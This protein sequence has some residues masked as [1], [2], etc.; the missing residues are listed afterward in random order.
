MIMLEKFIDAVNESHIN[1][2]SIIITKNNHTERHFFTETEEDAF[3]SVRSISKTVSCLGAFVAVEK[4]VYDLETNILQFFDRDKIT[5]ENNI[6]FL[7]KMK[8]KH[9]MNLTIGREKDL[10]FSKDIKE[11]IKEYPDTDFVYDYILKTDIKHNPG[12]YFVYNN[13]ATYL[14]CAITQKLLKNVNRFHR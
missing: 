14:L 9:L 7:E 11:R 12:E 8:I 6:L 5:N 10:M 4:G 1:V 13:A 3:H 2:D